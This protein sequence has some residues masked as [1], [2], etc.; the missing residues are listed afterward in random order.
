MRH[1][2]HT[3]AGDNKYDAQT[4]PIGRLCLHAMQIEFE[5]PVT[6][7]VMNFETKIPKAFIDIVRK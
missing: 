2:G 3:L 6:G 1:I 5:H 4:D 7:E